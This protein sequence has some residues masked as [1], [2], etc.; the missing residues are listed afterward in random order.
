MNRNGHKKQA[1]R[2]PTRTQRLRRGD[3]LSVAGPGV[4]SN[5]THLRATRVESRDTRPR[6]FKQRTTG[7]Q[8]RSTACGKI[9]IG[10]SACRSACRSVCGAF[11][12][13]ACGSCSDSGTEAIISSAYRCT[14]CRI[15]RQIRSSDGRD[16]EHFDDVQSDTGGDAGGCVDFDRPLRSTL[17]GHPGGT[18]AGNGGAACSQRRHPAQK[19]WKRYRLDR[20]EQYH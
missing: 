2:L 14:G 10:R 16:A 11:C 12:R 7:P 20:A 8:A 1:R 3:C 18:A 19:S 4:E 6:G 17:S 15:R 13:S 5:K 9:G